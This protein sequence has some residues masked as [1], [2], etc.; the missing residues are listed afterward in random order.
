MMQYFEAPATIKTQLPSVFLAGGITDCPNWQ[1]QATSWFA[2]Q[3]VAVLNPRRSN[4][5]IHDPNAAERQ[6]C[7]EFSAL[8][9]ASVIL[10]WFPASGSTTQ[11]I[12]LYEL[13]RYAALRKPFVVGRDPNYVRRQD[14]DIQV[15][16]AF[17]TMKIYD[18]LECAV[19]AAKAILVVYRDVFVADPLLSEPRAAGERPQEQ[20]EP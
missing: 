9:T 4:F 11:P 8:G 6:I 2:G 19:M 10:F 5:P 18:R 13:G 3:E 16:L 14:V 17:P 15:G 7:W 20:E 1:A 12:A